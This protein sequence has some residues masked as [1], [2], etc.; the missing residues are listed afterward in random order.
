M[1]VA[2]TYIISLQD[3]L[4]ILACKHGS[5]DVI[6]YFVKICAED[7]LKEKNGLMQFPNREGKTG[8][9]FALQSNH[10]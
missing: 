10:K 2:K 7:K 1:L 3:S 9:F 6:K 8:L 4:F 5:I